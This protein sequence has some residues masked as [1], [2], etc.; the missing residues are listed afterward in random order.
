ME[1]KER[2]SLACSTVSGGGEDSGRPGLG[3]EDAVIPVWWLVHFHS[4]VERPSRPLKGRARNAEDGP[5][6]KETDL[7]SPS[8]PLC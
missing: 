5:G 7:G 2:V 6:P 8:A 3:W 4:S 1:K